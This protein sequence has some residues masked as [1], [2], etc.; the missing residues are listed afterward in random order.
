MKLDSVFKILL[1][2][3]AVLV[4]AD[5]LQSLRTAPHVYAQSSSGS[6]VYIEPGTTMLRA[7]DGSR[8]VLGKVLIDLTN[9][10]VWGLPTTVEQ[11]YPVDMTASAPPTSKPFL[12][13][14]FDLSRIKDAR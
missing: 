13:G 14:K 5:L 3:L 1:V 2:L 12:L 4:S 8:Q 7:P 9:G 6:G 11:P 10:N